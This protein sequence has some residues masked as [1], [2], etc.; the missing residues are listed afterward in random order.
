MT[1]PIH[2]SVS[3]V[4]TVAGERSGDLAR[5]CVRLEVTEGTDGLRTLKAEFVAVGDGA[6]GRRIGPALPGRA[7]RRLRHGHHRRPRARWRPARRLRRHHLR[8]RGGVRRRRATPGPGVRRG[9]ADAAADDPTD[10]QLHRRHQRGVTD[11]DIARQIADAHGLQS[12]VA[13]DGPRFDVV[14]QVNQSDLAFLR[15][16]ARRIQAELWCEGRTLHFSTRD[17]R[18]GTRVQL[19]RG[20]HLLSVRL[21]ADLAHQRSEVRVTGLR[22]R[23]RQVIDERAGDE[24]VVAESSSGRTGPQVVALALGP[25]RERPP[26]PWPLTF[27]FRDVAQ[28]GDQARAWAKAEMLRRA[29]AFVTVEA[30]TRGSPELVVGSIVELQDVGAAVRRRRLLRDPV[31][32]HL[33]PHRGPADAVRGR[34]RHRERGELMHDRRPTARHRATTGSIPRSSPSWST[35][36]GRVRCRCASRA[37]APTVTPTYA[38]GPAWSRRTPTAATAWRSCRT[39]APRCWSRS[40]PASSARP[41]SSA[42]AGTARP[43]RRRRATEANNLRL[44]RSRTDSALTFD[45]TAGAE[46]VT[47]TMKSGHRIEL[48]NQRGEVVIKHSKGPVI[49]MTTAGEIKMNCT[50]V[51]V[52]AAQVNVHA[53]TSTFDGVINCTTLIASVGVTSPLYSIG[54]GNLL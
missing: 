19:V 3:P 21:L 13:A 23:R 26:K 10:A 41:T 51:D 52:T 53:A 47:I 46:K 15:E 27:R 4:F 40:R 37:W 12:D 49:T 29:R 54:V 44:L 18:Q 8:P 36:P 43:R 30:L 39:S 9:R 16:R 17:R 14:Q 31:L 22:L 6:T 48:D 7:D 28:S 35:R 33:R 50:T 11:A 5:D 1:D 20:G 24:V 32:P 42:P 25:S 34:A 2:A 38:P 45:D